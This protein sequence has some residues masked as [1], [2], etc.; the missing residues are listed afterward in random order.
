MRPFWSAQPKALA[1]CYYD[2]FSNPV[3]IQE[4]KQA[5]EENRKA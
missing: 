4:V 3:L 1:G 2:F 5:L